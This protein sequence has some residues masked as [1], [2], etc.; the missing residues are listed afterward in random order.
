MTSTASQNTVEEYLIE[1]R[2]THGRVRSATFL[3][4]R[5]DSR[6][7]GSTINYALTVMEQH[8]FLHKLQTSPTDDMPGY[9]TASIAVP[10]GPAG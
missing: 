7:E 6:V 4:S 5:C 2:K 8:A 10:P 9:E 3:C 1:V